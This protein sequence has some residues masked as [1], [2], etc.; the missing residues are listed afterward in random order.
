MM[1]A[2]PSARIGLG[3]NCLYYNVQTDFVD[4][5]DVFVEESAGPSTAM[6]VERGMGQEKR[7]SR[8]PTV[9]RSVTVVP[10]FPTAPSAVVQPCRTR[11]HF[12]RYG[13][14]RDTIDPGRVC[15]KFDMCTSI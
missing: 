4:F 10:P 2:L 14:I 7:A 5:D 3:I 11:R 1:A 13:L 15:F 6:E 8:G 12:A 9:L